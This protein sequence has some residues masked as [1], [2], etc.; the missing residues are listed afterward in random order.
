MINRPRIS[1]EELIADAL[2]LIVSLLVSALALYIFDIHQSFYPGQSVL[3]PSRYVFNT[4]TPFLVG[5]PIGGIIGFFI[6]K[7]VSFA[8][9]EDELAHEKE[10]TKKR[11]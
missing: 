9:M 7:I 11:R 2:Y 10:K 5:I 8:F 6:L 1:R 4:V 3:P